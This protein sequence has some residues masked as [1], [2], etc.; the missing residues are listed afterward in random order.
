[1][2]DSGIG[3]SE[4]FTLVKFC[5]EHTS[6]IADHLAVTELSGRTFTG[7]EPDLCNAFSNLDQIF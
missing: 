7:I 3:F 5:K 6:F 2:K 1:M 4:Q